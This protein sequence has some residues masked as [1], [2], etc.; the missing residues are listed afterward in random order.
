MENPDRGTPEDDRFAQADRLYEEG[1]FTEAFAAFLSL[2]EQGDTSAMTRV[3]IMYGT[4][5]GVARSFEDSIKWDM[6]AA[7]LGDVTG[8]F[9]LG[10]SYKTE[11]DIRESRRWFEKALA[12]G[13]GEAALELAK[14]SLEE[15]AE[16]AAAYL[17]RALQNGDLCE[18][19]REEAEHLLAGLRAAR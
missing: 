17:H 2:A 11:G 3:A 18:A 12:A 19:S 13:D 4:G 16:K 5:E 1:L 14:L 6:R 7:E 10:V 8:L 9:N 15:D